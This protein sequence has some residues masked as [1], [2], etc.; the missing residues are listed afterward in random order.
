MNNPSSIGI[1]RKIAAFGVHLFTSGGIVAGF[2]ALRA[3][4][5]HHWGEAMAWL[6]VGL[7]IDGLDG[8][9][10]R[11]ARTREVLPQWDGKAIDYVIDFANYAL[12]PAFFFY[13]A[14]LVPEGWSLPLTIAILLVS[15]LYYGRNGMVTEDYYFMG[16]PV[17]WNGAVFY[18]FFVW[19]LAP[20]VNA[21][22][23]ITFCIL[24]FVPIKYIYPSR[25]AFLKWLNI[26]ATAVFFL[27]NGLILFLYPDKVWWPIA[28]SNFSVLVMLFLG[29]YQTY[30]TKVQPVAK[31]PE[32][33]E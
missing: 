32:P 29:L 4:H 21:V 23:V 11:L 33:A 16:F 17:L 9:L 20:W 6:F 12:I 18:L 5:F 19:G 31:P 25:T 27:S 15:A 30:L 7:L 28:I 14:Q 24:H 22:V 13:E 26:L 8:T 1:G 2:M 3:I 10:A